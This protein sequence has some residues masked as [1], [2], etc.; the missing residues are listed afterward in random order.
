MCAGPYLWWE[1]IQRDRSDFDSIFLYAFEWMEMIGA[2]KISANI[3]FTRKC[4]FHVFF[5][6]ARKSLLSAVELNYNKIVYIPKSWKR[7]LA[8]SKRSFRTFSK[9]HDSHNQ[10][11]STSDIGDEKK[12]QIKKIGKTNLQPLDRGRFI[13]A[14]RSRICT[15]VSIM[16]SSWKLFFLKMKLVFLQHGIEKKASTARPSD[17]LCSRKLDHAYVE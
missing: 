6:S 5:L 4:I 12:T 10:H 9:Q 8:F 11:P 15:F 7:E 17:L 14:L 13:A 16:R 1:V 3:T 2:I